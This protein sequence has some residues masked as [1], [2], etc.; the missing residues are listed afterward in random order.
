MKTKIVFSI[1]V[2]L[3]CFSLEGQKLKHSMHQTR[4]IAEGKK[5]LDQ[6][7]GEYE[8]FKAK[9]AVLDKAFHDRNPLKVNDLKE[10]LVTDMIREVE[11]SA[12]KAKMARIE[13]ERERRGPGQTRAGHIDDIRDFEEQISRAERQA[14][15][16]DR[17]RDYHFGF[18]NSAMEKALANKALLEE[19]KDILREDIVATKREL[20][21]DVR[22]RREDRW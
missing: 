17:I 14:E 22:D 11:Q 18:E 6:D 13:I 20:N 10:R 3:L 12:K 15:I 4:Q 9:M 7:I 5:I 2:A 16:L 8:A 21:E 1:I 19:F